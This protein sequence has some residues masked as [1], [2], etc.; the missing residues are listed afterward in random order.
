MLIMDNKYE[1]ITQRDYQVKLTSQ[2]SHCNVLQ[3]FIDWWP[4]YLVSSIS[5]QCDF[6]FA[7]Y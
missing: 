6:K 4:F 3:V 1:L 7:R 5:D 2:I